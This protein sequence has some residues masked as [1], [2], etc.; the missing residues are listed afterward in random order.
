MFPP[1]LRGSRAIEKTKIRR[2]RRRRLLRVFLPIEIKTIIIIIILQVHSRLV[3]LSLVRPVSRAIPFTY[4]SAL[5]SAAES[6]CVHT[7]VDLRPR[8]RRRLPRPFFSAPPLAR[9]APIPPSLYHPPPPGSGS[10]RSLCFRAVCTFTDRPYG[11]YR[12]WWLSSCTCVRV[13]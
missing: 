2:I 1:R 7:T 6:Y 12:L 13:G 11:L 10:V 5:I 8:R 4:R 3:A 9:R